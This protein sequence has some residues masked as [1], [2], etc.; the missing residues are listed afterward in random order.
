[1]SAVTAAV[2][3]FVAGVLADS[4]RLGLALAAAAAI[5]ALAYT[6]LFLLL[7][8]LTRRPVLFGLA[9]ILVWEGL[10]GNLVSGTRSFSIEQY[11]ITF[12]DL[13]APT[14][15]LTGQVSVPVSIVMSAIFALGGTL[16]A[17]NR[18]GSFSMAGETS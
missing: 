3:L 11:V 9:Y 15:L 2:P 14:D 5:G 1:V 13:I 17:I 4:A 8:L 10:L 7:S 12:A 18:L 6:A 16:Y